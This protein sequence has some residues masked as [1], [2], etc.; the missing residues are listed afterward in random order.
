MRQLRDLKNDRIHVKFVYVNMQATANQ[1]NETSMPTKLTKDEKERWHA[2]KR[3]NKTMTSTGNWSSGSQIQFN[4]TWHMTCRK[5]IE[6]VV[7]C[8]FQKPNFASH[9]VTFFTWSPKNTR[10]RA[11]AHM[12][13]SNGVL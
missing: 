12:Y 10:K 7:D 13:A 11:H 4:K 9:A 3:T 5:D 8:A 6:T 2:T 1:M